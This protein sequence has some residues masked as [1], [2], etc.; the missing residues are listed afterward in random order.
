[1]EFDKCAVLMVKRALDE[2]EEEAPEA[3]QEDISDEA[4]NTFTAVQVSVVMVSQYVRPS[5]YCEI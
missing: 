5:L 4:T 3:E 2:D 1:M